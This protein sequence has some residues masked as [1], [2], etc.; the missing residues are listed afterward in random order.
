MIYHI[1]KIYARLS[2]RLFCADIFIHDK[3]AFQQKGPLLIA[4]NHP[5]SF[6]DAVIV[7]THTSAKTYILVR[8]DVFTNKWADLILRFLGCIPIFRIGDGRTKLGQNTLTFQECLRIF[9]QGNNVLIFSEGNCENE[10]RLRPLG[11]GTARLAFMSWQSPGIAA[12]LKVIPAG[13]TYSHFN[14][15]GKKV[16]LLTGKTIH[17]DHTTKDD[18]KNLTFFNEYLRSQLKAN[19][20]EFSGDKRQMQAMSSVVKNTR[21][22]RKNFDTTLFKNLQLKLTTIAN[23][24]PVTREDASIFSIKNILLIPFAFAGWVLHAPF[25]YPIKTFTKAKTKGTVYYDSVLFGILLLL[26][27]FYLILI[28]A[29]LMAITHNKWYGLTM[30]VTPLLGFVAIRSGFAQKI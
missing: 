19:M 21:F 23:G 16:I 30:I 26:Y 17:P 7:A 6:M 9:E 14:G 24:E 4:S 8:G 5:N 15:V 20:V 2:L 22:S 28:T 25:Y 29:V 11:K 18:P 27:P 3:Q 12:Q 1:L 10:W 13:F